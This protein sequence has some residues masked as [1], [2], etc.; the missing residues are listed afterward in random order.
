MPEERVPPKVS[1]DDIPPFPGVSNRRRLPARDRAVVGF[2]IAILAL[3]SL[4]CFFVAYESYTPALSLDK[5]PLAQQK[6]T[7]ANFKDLSGIVTERGEKIF[8][9][10]LS[11]GLLPVFATVIGFLLGQGV[12]KED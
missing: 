2:G 7:V 3:I 6:E 5:I 1:A 12:K 11:K 8:D 4:L 10:M 9:V